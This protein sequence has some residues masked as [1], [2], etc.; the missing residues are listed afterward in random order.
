MDKVVNGTDAA[1]NTEFT[2]TLNV[3]YADGTKYITDEK[4]TLTDGSTPWSKVLPKNAKYTITEAANDDF[5]TTVTANGD[6]EETLS[7]NATVTFT[8]TE[9]LDLTVEKQVSGKTAETDKKF[10]FTVTYRKPNGDTGTEKFSLVHG[11]QK[12]IHNLPYDT[13]YTVTEETVPGYTATYSDNATGTLEE[14]TEVTVTNTAKEHN[15]V[16]S[17]QVVG[18][19]DA[20]Q[21]EFSFTLSVTR[22]GGTTAYVPASYTLSTGETKTLGDGNTFTLK[23][24][25]T[26]EFVLP[27]GCTYQVTETKVDGYL[28]PVIAGNAHVASMIQDETATFT[29]TQLVTLTLTKQVGGNMGSKEQ[30]FR[31]TVKLGTGQE[32]TAVTGTASFSNGEYTVELAH[33]QSVVFTV[34]YGTAYEIKESDYSEE[35]YRTE[36]F[37]G[38]SEDGIESPTT[39]GNVTAAT[40]VTYKNSKG[41]SIPTGLTVAVL[42]FL[43]MVLFGGGIGITQLLG[44][45]KSRRGRYLDR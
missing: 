19:A 41:F 20:Q 36:I 10:E 11:E 38:D 45:R 37:I 6:G 5:I 9:L 22:S 34:P 43:G 14:D 42:P 2:F 31:F 7:D 44:G 33:D 1:K 4:F 21:Q 8:N 17:K 13:T 30:P 28:D 27:E 15:L 29:N 12:I 18:D 16:V 25:Q 32:A 39:N 23:H 26:A 24:G 35:G 40:A 3:W